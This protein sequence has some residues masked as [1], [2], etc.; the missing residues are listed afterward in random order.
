M[1][2]AQEAGVPQTTGPPIPRALESSVRFF[3]S[4]IETKTEIVVSVSK[5]V[6]SVS[7]LW[8]VVEKRPVPKGHSDLTS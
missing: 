4:Y 5:I 1:V 6:V 2:G 7:V 3:V 8:F